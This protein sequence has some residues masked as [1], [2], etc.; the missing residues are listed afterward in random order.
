M[1]GACNFSY[2]TELRQSPTGPFFIDQYGRTLLPRGL[3]VSGSCKFPTTA[4]PDCTNPR[5]DAFWKEGSFIGRPFPLDTAHDHL[6]RL[7]GWG[8]SIIRL[9][10]TWEAIEPY[11]EVLDE[12]YLDYLE[13]IVAIAG[14][15]G[16]LVVIDCHQDCWSR[17][18]GGSGAPLWTFRVAGLNPRLFEACGA[19][20]L[21]TAEKHAK[22]GTLWATNYTKFAVNTMFT[23]FFAGEVFAPN[24]RYRGRNVGLYL[25]D[26]YFASFGALANRL[27][28]HKCVIGFDP[29]N[30]PHHGFIGLNTL[31]KFNEDVLLHLGEM[32][33]AVQSMRLAAGLPQDVGV[34]THSWPVP[35]KR[36][37]TVRMNREGVSCWD[38]QDIW[39][40]HGVYSRDSHID[41]YFSVFPEHHER[42]GQKVDFHED[43]YQPFLDAF[44]EI[45]SAEQ[46]LFAEPVPNALDT[47]LVIR[48]ERVC[49]APHWYDLKAL[50]EKAWSPYISFN[51]QELSRGSRNLLKHTYLGWNGVVRNYS[52]QYKS[53]F[54]PG[55]SHVPRLI[56]ETG[57]PFDMNHHYVKS[58]RRGRSDDY[59][60]QGQM[61]DAMCTAM[62]RNLL[63]YTLWN[64]TP[65]NEAYNGHGDW[66]NGEDFSIY[67][68]E[69]DSRIG[70]YTGTRAPESW[71]RPHA[72]KIAGTPTYSAFDNRA[73]VYT[74]IFT[75]S[76]SQDKLGR[77]TEIFV[78]TIHV[79][80]S[81]KPKVTVK[82]ATWWYDDT[83]QT[84][85]V[86]HVNAEEVR[87][88][89]H[90]I[91]TYPW[92][93]LLIIVF[94]Y[95]TYTLLL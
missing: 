7:Q 87:I 16:L 68:T 22:A 28:R 27:K 8:T 53:L 51:V 75:P 73:G 36:T 69:P 70:K 9:L 32:P 10:V 88:T 1:D 84:L 71:I 31:M 95:L 19:A 86:T 85:Y 47:P 46:W 34:Y 37:S 49:F 39:L 60:V 3:N 35:T 29:M 89:I 55:N 41:D 15:Y 81:S 57:I 45:L 90:F 26:R 6:Q 52:S 92:H 48:N 77:T 20:V 23:L 38:G 82:N 91:D 5:S 93:Y 58:R 63:N 18:T 25:R 67:S 14:E 64:Y 43:F 54:A 13:Q 80:R 72:V 40:D 65:E 4:F 12:A 24:A 50:F 30:E 94:L 76:V 83:T 56:G 61:L 74:L 62:E 33:S 59:H 2:L 11:P 79:M 66:W 42:A 44:S 21:H 17:F 78:P